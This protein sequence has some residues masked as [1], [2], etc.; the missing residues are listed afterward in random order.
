MKKIIIGLYLSIFGSESHAD[1]FS[2]NQVEINHL[3]NYDGKIFFMSLKQSL[4]TDCAYDALYCTA[5]FCKRTYAL[6]L[7]AKLADR[8]LYS[9]DYVQ[10]PVT[11][12]CRIST[13]KLN[14]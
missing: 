7:A 1:Q 10:D 9:V 2:L 4:K 12:Y 8:K 13:V 14:G 6:V 3:G 11:K 5:A